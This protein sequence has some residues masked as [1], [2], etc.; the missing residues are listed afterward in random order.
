VTVDDATWHWGA[1]GPHKI[2]IQL[3]NA[4]HQLIEQGT[5]EITMPAAKPRPEMRQA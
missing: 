3:I 4:N 5:V 2:L 1:Q